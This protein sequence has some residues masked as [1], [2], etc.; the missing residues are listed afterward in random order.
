MKF[1]EVRGF[2][3]QPSYGTNSYDNW[4]NF[5]EKKIKYELGLGKKYFPKMNTVR[6]WLSFDAYNMNPDKFM[7]NFDTY[8]NIIGEYG[9]KVIPCFLNRWHNGHQDNGGEYIETI[10]G[11]RDPSRAPLHEAYVKR[12]I[13]KYK[14]D[15]RVLVWDLC[16]EPFYYNLDDF[17]KVLM[18][19]ELKWLKGIYAAAK[20]VNP[21]APLS[22]SMHQS[23]GAKFYDYIDCISDVYLLH[24]YFG[25]GR[26]A[27]KEPFKNYT[28]E[29]VDYAHSKG[30]E[31]LVTECC[32][33]A[34]DDDKRLSLIVPSLDTFDE[35]GVGYIIHA[36]M[37]SKCADLHY[38]NE[39]P[40]NIPEN[41]SFINAD[42]SL[43]K[44]HDIFNKY[45][46]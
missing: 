5:D 23:H 38:K 6:I 43:R 9:L 1:S 21:T 26:F 20:S 45:C 29:Y 12:I 4:M 2:N 35:L 34:D 3:Y 46:K 31:A 33:G 10:Y 36:L 44:N 22:V 28:K 13:E 18:E 11:T 27:E 16:N 39:G 40:W 42:G 41:L 25:N 14:D 19:V 15:E 7:D 30:K 32:W 24:P 8:M 17:G 37:N